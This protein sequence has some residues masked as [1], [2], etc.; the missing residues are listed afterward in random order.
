MVYRRKPQ[1]KRVVRYKKKA[2]MYKTLNLGHGFPKTLKQT[3][4]YSDSGSL[5]STTNYNSHLFSCNGI[6]DPNITGIGTQPNYFDQMSLI[7]NH[8]QVIG[9]KITWKIMNNTSAPAT[10][11]VLTINDD[12]TDATFATLNS[13]VN[14]NGSKHY[15]LSTGATD[16]AKTSTQRWSQKKTFGKNSLGNKDFL[17]TIANNPAEQ[18][19]FQLSTQSADFVTS[20]TVRF[21]AT[22]EYIVLWSE[23]KDVTPS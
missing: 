21:W 9:S 11:C 13:L 2:P 8:Y 7:Y 15:F 12:T 18:S 3:L 10:R 5:T 23:L 22:I 14:K 17:G 16:T 6:Y 20:T 4:K 19:Y 1:K